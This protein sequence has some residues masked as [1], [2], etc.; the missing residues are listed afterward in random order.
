MPLPTLFAKQRL[1]VLAAPMFLVS[2]KDLVIE[3]CGAGVG[4]TFPAL[5]KRSS[6]EFEAWL[7]EVKAALE[8]Q[9]LANPAA[10]WGPYG[11]NLIVH[12]SNPR[13]QA[14]LAIC[15]EQQVPLVIT[16]LGAVREVVDAVHGY[17]G[18]VFHD[19]TNLRH[20]RKAIE[21]GV[22]GLVLVAAGAGGHAGTINP[23]ALVAEIRAHFD[24]CI[25]LAG[26]LSTGRDVLA[27]QAMGADLA[28]MGTRFIATR[29]SQAQ[30]GYKQMLLQ[31]RPADIV[32]TPAV[33]GVPANFMRQSLEQ[34]GFDM[35]KLMSAGDVDF[36]KKLTVSDE[37][38]AW[39]T[40]WSAGHGVASIHDVPTVRELVLRLETEYRAARTSLPDPG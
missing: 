4:A 30:E 32:H 2:E 14:D 17:G 36:G 10:P 8:A 40:I 6:E 7:V 26:C 11:V 37:A 23:F 25:I 34:N 20:A 24:G 21:A 18:I 13:M 22:D 33:S 31:A 38:K 19:V 27:A 3:A 15:V 12:R 9:R 1:P 29:E 5:N 35:E 16:S 39:K 28:Y